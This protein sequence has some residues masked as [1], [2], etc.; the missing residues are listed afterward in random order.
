MYDSMMLPLFDYADIVRGDQDNKVLMQ[1]LQ[2]LQNKV[3][4]GSF[5][6]KPTNFRSKFTLMFSDFAKNWGRF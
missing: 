2:T 5:H 4:K 3:A 1:S 6:V